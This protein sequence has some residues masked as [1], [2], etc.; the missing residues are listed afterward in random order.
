MCLPVVV[1]FHFRH[2]LCFAENLRHTGSKLLHWAHLNYCGAALS[3]RKLP[4]GDVKK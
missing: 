4:P 3:Q 1:V 2:K